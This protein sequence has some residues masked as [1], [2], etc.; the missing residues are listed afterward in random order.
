MSRIKQK[1]GFFETFF[2]KCLVGNRKSYTFAL[3]SNKKTGAIKKEFFEKLTY[4]QR[5]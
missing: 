5:S 1:T 2:R 3:A 4:R